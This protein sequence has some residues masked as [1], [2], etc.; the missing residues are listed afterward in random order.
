M[1]TTCIVEHVKSN[2]TAYLHIMV[3]KTFRKSH[4]DAYSSTIDLSHKSHHAPVVPC[5]KNMHTYV[6][7]GVRNLEI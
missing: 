5:C 4:L 7:I 6:H 1:M 2:L 3:K